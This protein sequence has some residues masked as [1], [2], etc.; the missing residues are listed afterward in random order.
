M[1]AL[2]LTLLLSAAGLL[3]GGVVPFVLL[4]DTDA[5]TATARLETAA[6]TPEEETLRM[7]GIAERAAGA[8]PEVATVFTVIGSAFGDHG[9]E[10]AADPATVGQ[11]VLELVPADVRQATGLETSQRLLADLRRETAGLPGVKRLS[12]QGRSGGPSGADIEVLL[13]GEEM[14]TVQRAVAHVR[15]LLASYDGVDEIF[16][17]LQL[18]KLE[19]R[20][21]LRPAG[22]LLGLTT[23]D[24]A[25]QV[26]H[27]LY[28]IEAQDLQI[29]D[30]EVTVRAVLPE[31]ARRSLDDLLRLRVV[32]PSGRRVP[33]DEVARMETTRGYASLSRVDGK[34]AVTITAEV[35]EDTANV[36]DVTEAL[37]A[38][39]ADIGA[40][41]DGVS[42]TFE[43]RRKETQESLG[44]L[45]I[46]FPAALLAI[47]SLIAVIFRSYTQPVIV[48]IVIPYALV[49]AILGHFVM[50]YPFTILSMIGA[51][52]LSGIVVNDGLILVDYA[53][54]Q[55][56]AGVGALEAIV[57]AGRA[58]LRPILLTSITT[59]AGLAP[60]MLETSFQAQFLIP[61][62]VSIVFGLAFATALT[63]LL[64]PMFYM[65]FEDVRMGL[66]WIW[67]N[68]YTDT[69]EAIPQ[70]GEAVSEG[71][72]D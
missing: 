13:R 24:L 56:R 44:S 15:D 58:R 47:F 38:D 52:A 6:G 69:L 43:G 49:G 51:V 64:L 2:S 23:R 46:G 42:L 50:G 28:G 34:R 7:L 53:N 9:P 19:A 70:A 66:R 20:L 59:I 41:Y 4:Q 54:R 57:S 8:H 5:E 65:I 55:R 72:R 63:L 27:A 60:I 12:W 37:R 67:T 62:A 11:L 14:E 61:M 68:R 16:D 36:R 71:V 31:A 39:V 29:G 18:G 22:R 1:A 35:D 48:M 10:V 26:R 33:L 45:A 17:N 30:E 21:R 40:L 25:I 3:V 32:T